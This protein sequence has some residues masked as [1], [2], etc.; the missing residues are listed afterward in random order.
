MKNTNSKKNKTIKNIFYNIL[1]KAPGRRF[2]YAYL[3]INKYINKN[4]FFRF[5][6]FFLGICLI[7][8]S[9]ILMFTPG[10]GILFFLLG[11]ALLCVSSK[12]IAL[13]FDQA[14]KKAREHIH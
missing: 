2:T 8:L 1:N 3:V 14:E 7:L 9:I 13:L 12:K 4:A 6:S 11:V 10:P 5:F